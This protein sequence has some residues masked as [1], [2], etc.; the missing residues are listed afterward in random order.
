MR[1]AD[2]QGD[3][4]LARVGGGG[5]DGGGFDGGAVA[6]ADE[7]EDGGVAFGD[8]EDVVVEVGA[9]CACGGGLGGGLGW[10]RCWGG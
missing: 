4:L 9:G 3:E 1:I 10:K 7:A 5:G 6:D 2:F 8:A